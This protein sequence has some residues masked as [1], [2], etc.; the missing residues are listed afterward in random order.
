MFYG[1]LKVQWYVHLGLC[2]SMAVL[3]MSG[4]EYWRVSVIFG[5]KRFHQYLLGKSFTIVSDYK[6]LQYLF[7]ES[8]VTPSL[9]SARIQ[10]WS[11]TLG[12]YSYNIE[13]KPGQHN[14]N[15]DMFSR[16]P[17]PETPTDVPIPGETVLVLDML[18]SLPV[19]VEQIR[20]WTTHDPILSRVRTLVQQGWQDTNDANL[21]PFQKRKNELSLHDG[22]VLWGSRVVVPPQGRN[23]IKQEL[24]EGHPGAT[25][26]KALARSFV[27][28]PQID[29]DLEELV[30][31]C[32]DCQCFRNQPP[33]APLQQWEWPEKPWVRVHADYAG[34]FLSRQ[35]LI[36]VDAHS[37]WMEVKAVTNL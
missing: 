34:P 25:R 12:A 9:A 13:Y 10:H 3:D 18:L 5:V 14:G 15:A 19:T 16:L 35:F 17:L 4:V 33:V 24:H 8:R 1:F 26:M 27:W 23:K 29:R 21:K 36:L 37:K 6:P 32:E 20:Q 30:K 22:C 11:W 7:S 2:I 31:R 28:W